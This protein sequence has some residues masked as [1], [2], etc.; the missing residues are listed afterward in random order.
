MSSLDSRSLTGPNVFHLRSDPLVLQRVWQ[1]DVFNAQQAQLS[2]EFNDTISPAQLES[3]LNITT[4]AGVNVPYKIDSRH[5]QKR[6]GITLQQVPT[7]EI[8]VCVSAGLQ[9]TSGPLGL[10]VN[11]SRTVKLTHEFR[12]QHVSPELR[13]FGSGS[14]K[15]TFNAPVDL[16]TARDFIRVEPHVD[17][18]V[19]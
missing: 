19:D 17:T 16:A 14:V 11:T 13:H 8:V 2:L 15:V 6:V 9:S 3:H 18:S 12:V 7:N 5:N 10:E 1:T 4:T